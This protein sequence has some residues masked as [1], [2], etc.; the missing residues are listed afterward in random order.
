MQPKEV[1]ASLLAKRFE[2]D[3]LCE[4]V[5]VTPLENKRRLAQIRTNKVWIP[6]VGDK[7]SS[8]HGQ[9]GVVGAIYSIDSMPFCES[10]GMRPTLLMNSHA[11]PSRMTI[12]HIEEIFMGKCGALLS[13]FADGTPHHLVDEA[14]LGDI[15]ESYG[16]ARSGKE[17]MVSGV[18]G[19]VIEA[20]IFV[21]VQ[22]YQRLKQVVHDKEQARARGPRNLKTRQPVEGRSYEGGMRLGEM[23]RDC[24]ISHGAACTLQE[25]LLFQSDNYIATVC[26]ECGVLADPAYRPSLNTSQVDERVKQRMSESTLRARRAWCRECQSSKHIRL[27]RMPYIFKVVLQET[28]CMGIKLKLELKDS[29]APDSSESWVDAMAPSIGMNFE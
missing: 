3:A 29:V 6:E 24:I 12:G 2:H 11:F 9:K 22:S 25:R 27:V 15:L 17:R 19:E 10:T 26:K 14:A 28:Y 8:R 13:K 18:T 23:E 20:D 16:F 5:F 4:S 21:G 1:D 7:F